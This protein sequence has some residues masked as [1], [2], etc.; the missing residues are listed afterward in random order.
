MPGTHVMND[1]TQLVQLWKQL[2]APFAL[3]LTQ[4]GF[5]RFAQWVTG[6]VLG[7][8]EH[9]ITQ[10]LTSIGLEDRWR[11]LERFAEYGAFRRD[12]VEQQTRNLIET[13][14]Q[15]RFQG[16]RVVAIDDTKCHRT[17]SQVWGT[18]TFHEPAGRSPNRASTVRAHNWVVAGDLVPGTPWTYLPHTSR[19]YFRKTQLPDGE[20]FCTKPELAVAMLRQADANSP[21]PILAVFDGAY[22]NQSVLGP[23]LDPT[24]GRRIDVVTRLRFDARLYRPLDLVGTRKKGRPRKWGDRLP[25]PE[26]HGQWGFRW[27]ETQGYVYGRQRQVRIKERVC[28]WSVTGPTEPVRVIVAQVEGYAEPWYL[29]TT[30]ATLKAIEVVE[31][32]AA[33]FRQEDGFRDHKQR[34][35]MEECRAWTKAPIERTFAVQVVAQTLLKL[36]ARRLDAT[37]GAGGWWSAPEWN[38]GKQHA[39]LLDVRRAMWAS[40]QA[41]SD[42]LREQ[43]DPREIATAA[44]DSHATAA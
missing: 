18:C 8:E 42:F 7:W 2:L 32:F 39:T 16:Y 13:E 3:V 12:A 15:P 31:L 43:D 26:Q 19:L 30:S 24:Q 25:A 41:F 6:T 23:C 9:T 14:V 5:V 28:R 27:Q 10:I 44:E 1:A 22:A 33:R 35:G 29:V 21:V 11:V 20:T 40:R 36:L 38:R 4:P 17:S 34:L 37:C